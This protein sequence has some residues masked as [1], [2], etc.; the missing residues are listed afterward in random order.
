M[1][2]PGSINIPKKSN[3][4]VEAVAL[5]TVIVLFSQLDLTISRSRIVQLFL[6]S[7]TQNIS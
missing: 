2:Y 5:N 6:T 1:E 3:L 7:V 4:K